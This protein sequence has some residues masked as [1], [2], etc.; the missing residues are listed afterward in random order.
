VLTGEF[1]Y[2]NRPITASAGLASIHPGEDLESLIRRADD[3]LYMAKHKG[4]NR[5]YMHDGHDCVP[6]DAEL[7]SGTPWQQDGEAS[8]ASETLTEQPAPA[9]EPLDAQSSELLDACDDLKSAMLGA[10]GSSAEVAATPSG[11]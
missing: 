8:A 3:A 4:R 2:L 6:L 5:T 7:A 1:E 10:V 11:K 9:G